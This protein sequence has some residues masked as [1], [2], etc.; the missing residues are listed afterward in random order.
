MLKPSGC[1]RGVARDANL[2]SVVLLSRQSTFMPAMPPSSRLVS[3]SHCRDPEAQ[4][5][6]ADAKQQIHRYIR[7]GLHGSFDTQIALQR[8]II[9]GCKA[10]T[11]RK[12]TPHIP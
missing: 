5:K 10:R 6:T 3:P 12:A 1:G 4:D 7:G 2:S 11:G 9:S 8:N